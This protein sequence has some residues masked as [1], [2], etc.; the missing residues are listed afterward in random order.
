MYSE[1]TKNNSCKNYYIVLDDDNKE[2]ETNTKP[3]NKVATHYGMLDSGTTNHFIS[4]QASV[5]NV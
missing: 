5:K 1:S 2:E 4:V 3:K